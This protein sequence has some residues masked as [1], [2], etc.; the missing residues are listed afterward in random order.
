MGVVFVLLLDIF[1]LPCFWSVRKITHNYFEFNCADH[2]FVYFLF[3]YLLR[4]VM[5][6]HITKL[7]LV[8][9]SQ[10][11]HRENS[12]EGRKCFYLKTHSAHLIYGYMASDM[13]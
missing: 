10:M 1:S 6:T 13:V 7:F 8:V 11:I 4:R 3:F 12:K 2:R 5:L 9:L